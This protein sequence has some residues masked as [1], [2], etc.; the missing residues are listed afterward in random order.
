MRLF[1]KGT[2][3]IIIGLIICAAS[4]ATLYFT[5][6]L[7][8]APPLEKRQDTVF[9]NNGAA[10]IEHPNL[11]NESITLE[12]VSPLLLQAMVV[13]EDQHFYDHYG[14]DF[15]GIARAIIKNVQSS[16]LKEGAS[17]ITQ[18][19]A[20]NL[21]LT[22][23]K[24]LERKVKEALYTI[25][26]EMFYSKE[27]ILESYINTI[28]Y[29]HGA[30]GITA[31]S[32]VFFDKTPDALTTGEAAML[33]GIPKG[34]T[35]YSPFNDMEKA[36]T[37]Q[38]F[39]LSLLRQHK[40]ITSAEYHEA[41]AEE[42]HYNEKDEQA[43]TTAHFL[44]LTL[45]EASKV[46]E[47]EVD[48]ILTN[49][50]IIETTLD[51]NLQETLSK[52]I[53]ENIDATNEIEIG[54]LAIQP[55][56]GAILA[57]VGG[58]PHI[59]SPFNRVVDA[60]RMVGS[61]FKPLLYYAALENGFTPTTT[62]VSEPTT[63]TLKN[64]TTYAPKNYNGYY[65]N[66]PI[67]LAEAIAVSDNIYAVK[68]NL[69]LTPKIVA[70]TTRKFG[71]T[72]N[73][74]EVPSLA[75]GSAAITVDEMVAAYGTIANGG[76]EIHNYTINK[77]TTKDKKTVYKKTRG[78]SDQILHPSK[79]FLLTHLMTGMFD[80]RLN[81]YTKVTGASIAPKLTKLYA[82]KSG[83]TDFDSWMIGY[84][85]SMVTGV[86]VGYDDNRHLTN[87]SD[88]AIAKN[89]WAD[90][91]EGSHEDIETND[92]PVPPEMTW[93]MIDP[94]SGL[95]ATKACPVSKLMYFEKGTEPV[96]HCTQHAPHH[97]ETKQEPPK[98]TQGFF[99][100]LVDFFS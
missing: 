58:N 23:E 25:R 67:T 56:D 94:A 46:L 74:P 19:L 3:W 5:C 21:Y 99:K 28:Y 40:Y 45:R 49:G 44:D 54:A 29:G 42:L 1:W 11:S 9:L 72:S 96:E 90:Y 83:T 63:F 68:T 77:I 34:P 38:Q 7:L 50:Y 16:E 61:A 43:Q 41:I 62:L 78:A 93:K 26:L 52:T 4:I 100:K 13:V 8:G 6:Y 76:E 70:D 85:P 27:E 37:R 10:V 86:W 73:L 51:A 87:V 53:R 22:H 82:G 95:L 97:D 55:D 84:S 17:T 75:L 71:I 89:V 92:F 48:S 88:Y 57:L 30:Y 80:E 98:H 60:K 64:E 47:E 35:Y 66:K 12:E 33:A 59:N 39:I 32:E 65:A 31:A 91:M 18:Q 2:K 20:R 14:F 15:R 81:S 24:T 79:A 69:F 36:R